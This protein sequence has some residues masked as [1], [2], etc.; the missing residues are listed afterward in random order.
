M[1]Q[2]GVPVSIRLS[3]GFARLVGSRGDRKGRHSIRINDQFRVC[4]LWTAEGPDKV[5]IVGYH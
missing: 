3:R 1:M 2:T 4:F 5:E